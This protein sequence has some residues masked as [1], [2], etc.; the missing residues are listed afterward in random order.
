MNKLFLSA[1][2]LLSLSLLGL[3]PEIEAQANALTTHQ[4]QDVQG[5]ILV[6]ENG[7]VLRGNSKNLHVG[8]EVIVYCHIDKQFK[9]DYAIRLYHK[10]TFK[11]FVFIPIDFGNAITVTGGSRNHLNFHWICLTD[12]TCWDCGIYQTQ[13]AHPEFF[14][15]GDK[16]LWSYI[17]RPSY[18]KGLILLNLNKPTTFL[19]PINF[20]IPPTLYDWGDNV[21]RCS[22]V[23]D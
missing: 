2:F 23:R 6:L 10:K 20:G 13:N 12:E 19:K 14:E 18:A 7:L 17:N 11:S 15:S 4:V 22:G 8:D 5:D 3:E 1:F 16:V 21:D 9:W